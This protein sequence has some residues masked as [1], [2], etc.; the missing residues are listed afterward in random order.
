MKISVIIPTYNESLVIK[1]CLDSLA[2]QTRDFELIIVD[3]GSID[4]TLEIVHDHEL[5]QKDT[6]LKIEHK[7]PAAARNLGAQKAS[8]Q[9]LVFVDADM[10]FESDFLN[11][12]VRPIEQGKSK[13]TFSKQ[14]IVSNWDVVWARCWNYNQGIDMSMRTPKNYPD[15]APVFRA[16]LASEFSRV[17]GYTEGIGWTDD[18]TLSRKL[19]F[20][21]T[22]TEAKYYHANPDTLKE[23]YK[24]ARW[25]G[26][27]EFISGTFIR[28]FLNLIR[29]SFF[30]S[31]ITSCIKSFQYK[32]PLF[33]FFKLVYDFA[34]ILSIIQVSLGGHRNK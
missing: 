11:E 4:R 31:L 3:D 7:G 34:I 1:A 15:T 5:A 12:L 29:Y 16:I 27:N 18:W 2:K 30:F 17:N 13:G 23:V 21:S 6:I 9:I 26:K 32:T 8:G 22:S 28:S 33:I 20:Q 25:I 10:T 19:G 14:E 24:Q